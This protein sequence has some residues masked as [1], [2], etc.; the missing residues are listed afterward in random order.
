MKIITLLRMFIQSMKAG[1]KTLNKENIFF[2]LSQKNCIIILVLKIRSNMLNK[3][4]GINYDNHA[5]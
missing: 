1:I 2:E 3:R 5:S 4:R